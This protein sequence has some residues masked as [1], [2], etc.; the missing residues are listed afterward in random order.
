MH[1]VKL[2]GMESAARLR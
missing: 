2:S 1:Q